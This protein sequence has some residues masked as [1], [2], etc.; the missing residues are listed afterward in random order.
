PGTVIFEDPPLHTRHRALLSRMFT[1]RTV[2]SLE[3]KIRQY[4][5]DALA[6]L[7]GTDSF[8]LV[9]AYASQVPMRVISLLF[10]V[11][12]ELQ[13][14][15]RDY[16]EEH[17][18]GEE[19][20][21]PDVNDMDLGG[22]VFAEYVDWRAKNPSDDMTTRLLTT[23][24]EDHT[25]TVR[26]LTRE[27][28]LAYFTIISGA[29]NETTAKL[30]GWTGKLLAEHPDQRRHIVEDRS[31]L[32]PAIEEILRFE[33]VGPQNARYV[34][35]PVEFHGDTIPAGS[36]LVLLMASGN[37][38]DRR[39]VRG[40]TFD[41]HRPPAPILTFAHGIHFCLGASLAR[42]EGRIALDELLNR[43]PEWDVDIDAAHLAYSP[44]TRGWDS[45]P[46]T[47]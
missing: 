27:E 14:T 22:G 26:T 21:P 3:P 5:I 38:D 15:F 28:V 45:L 37:R 33:T 42:L 12:E 8:D 32:V 36:V 30:I 7:D 34:A 31:L 23:E 44:V 46:V 13:Q 20:K 19:G 29:G 25:G 9:A 18:R 17:T 43:F 10:G 24:F 6:E 1:P 41:I 35:S 11:P 47:V 40:D 16:T 39:F 2:T 4:C